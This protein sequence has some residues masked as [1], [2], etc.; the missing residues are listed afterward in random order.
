MIL[1]G[2]ARAVADLNR[3]LILALRR[4]RGAPGARVRRADHQR[5]DAVVG[6]AGRLSR[7]D[8]LAWECVLGSLSDHFS[9]A[10]S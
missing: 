10:A 8:S 7:H 3:G 5:A 4:D 2:A 9:R 1:K 6:L